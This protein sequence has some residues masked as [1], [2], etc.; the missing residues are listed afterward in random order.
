MGTYINTLGISSSTIKISLSALL[1]LCSKI[2]DRLCFHFHSVQ[3]ILKFFLE[4]CSWAHEWFRSMLFSFQKF[5]LFPFIFLLIIFSFIPL[6]LEDNMNDFNSFKFVEI[7]FIAQSM[8]YLGI[9]SMGNWKECVFCY[10]WVKGSVNINLNLL[11]D[12]VFK[13]FK[14]SLLIFCLVIQW[15]IER[16][17]L[18][19]STIIVD[20]SIFPPSS[21]GFCF[22]Y[23]FSSIVWCIYI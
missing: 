15:I 1:E 13:V 19:S 14:I 4:S 20:F 3:G 17:V 8:V 5:A 16:G 6:W 9:Y 18:K 22:T 23:F 10:C 2:F 7:C 21:I 11:V 12:D